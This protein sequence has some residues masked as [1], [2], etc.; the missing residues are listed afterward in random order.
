MKN[1]R[2]IVVFLILLTGQSID[3][4]QAATNNL[5]QIELHK[6]EEAVLNNLK[7]VVAQK[8]PA[9]LLKVLDDTVIKIAQDYSDAFHKELANIVSQEQSQ[10]TTAQSKTTQTLLILENFIKKIHEI[11]IE[12]LNNQ[13][14][15]VTMFYNKLKQIEQDAARAL[16]I[17]FTR[18]QGW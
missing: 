5:Q 1:Y 8:D 16:L 17:S 6:K 3:Q 15:E 4:L 11:L 18:K 12:L 13:Q 14:P 7:A 10:Q 9:T 2:F